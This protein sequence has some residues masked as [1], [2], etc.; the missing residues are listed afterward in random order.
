[1]KK[2]YKE[3]SK[4]KTFEERWM[5]LRLL[6]V[7]GEETFGVARYLNQDFYRSVTWKKIRDLIIIRDFGCD[8]GIEGREIYGK[9]T[10]HHINP[11]SLQDIET[12]SKAILDLDNLILCSYETHQSIHYGKDSPLPDILTE[13]KPF[14]HIP[15]R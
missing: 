9:P 15:W 5:Y 7:V 4:L 13:R 8:L 1:M 12:F 10:I 11:L 14:D 3:L 6:G 2:S